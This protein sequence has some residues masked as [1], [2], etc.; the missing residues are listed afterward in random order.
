MK[1]TLLVENNSLYDTFFHAEHGLSAYVEED[2]VQVL[3]D[4]GYSDAFIKNAE[5]MGLD[6]TSV[7]YV[8]ISHGHYDHAGGLNKLMA[9]YDKKAVYRKPTLL[10]ADEDIFLKKYN[11]EVQ[12]KTGM[13]VEREQ[14]EKYFNVRVEPNPI[15]LTERLLYLGKAERT[16]PYEC[17]IPQN[18]KWKN[19][20][21]VD[22]F[23]D[24]DVQLGYVHQDGGISIL[25]GCSH[26]GICNI[27][28][29]AKK[30]T[31]A[32]VVHD[33]IGGLHLQ[34]PSKEL[35]NYTL[36]FVQEARI[37]NFYCCHCTDFASRLALAKVSNVR[38]AGVSLRLEW[39]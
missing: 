1:L 23:I 28:S 11:F 21:Y 3:Y 39:I 31:G 37:E 38:E 22:D 36:D 20:Q 26:S 13:T 32:S 33:V 7:D 10:V 18:K 19:N 9:Y 17:K 2:G 15:R 25:T 12:R 16:S 30:V 35:L 27:I 34:K 14:L 6:L 4:T 5:Q 29:N 24:E 8:V